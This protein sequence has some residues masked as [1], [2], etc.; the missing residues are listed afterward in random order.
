MNAS[1]ARYWCNFEDIFFVIFM[2][3]IT[4]ALCGLQ[5]IEF[6]VVVHC[7]ICKVMLKL[8]IF[9]LYRLCFAIKRYEVVGPKTRFKMCFI[10]FTFRLRT[11]KSAFG[12]YKYIS[13]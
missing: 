11:E 1:L 12:K 7:I 6:N 3:N 4:N 9:H 5:Y 13:S 8:Y 2:E 10:S